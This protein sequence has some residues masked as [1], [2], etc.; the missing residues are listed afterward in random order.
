MSKAEK[1]KL[2]PR[3]EVLRFK[4][5]STVEFFMET[6]DKTPQQ[7]ENENENED[8]AHPLNYPMLYRLCHCRRY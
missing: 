2:I 5:Y 6:A 8:T 3:V 4:I 7:N 1:G